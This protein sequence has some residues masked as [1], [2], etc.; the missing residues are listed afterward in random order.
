VVVI[1]ILGLNTSSIDIGCGLITN[2]TINLA[3]EEERL[4]RI[5]HHKGFLF[6]GGAP[7][8]SMSKCIKEINDKLENV[9]FGWDINFFNSLKLSYGHLYSII[10]SLI[11]KKLLKESKGI[12]SKRIF[13]YIKYNNF[14]KKIKKSSKNVYFIP[15]HLAHSASAYRVSGYKKCNILVLDAS[16]EKSSISLYIGEK[17]NLQLFK[18]FP[19]TSSLG[20]LYRSVTRLIGMGYYGEGNT[21]GLAPYGRVEKRFELIQLNKGNFKINYSKLVKIA[22]L[23]NKK[24]NPELKRNI[25]ATLQAKLEET[26]FF[27]CFKKFKSSPLK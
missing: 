20:N 13:S 14:I 18:D 1:N 22:L 3:I 15:H 16:G 11:S 24:N 2:N 19:L 10:I 21:M 6:G 7:E 12:A 27:N 4:S 9:A 26:A 5:K 25:A 23:L 8:L 17:G